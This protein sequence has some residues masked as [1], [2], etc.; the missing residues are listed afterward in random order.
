MTN[1]SAYKA[2][3]ITSLM[4][5]KSCWS[6]HFIKTDLSLSIP[7]L[8][9]SDL[10]PTDY[11]WVSIRWVYCVQETTLWGYVCKS[12]NV[13]KEMVRQIWVSLGGLG[14]IL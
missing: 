1:Y 4:K 13:N 9:E 14:M 6:Q 2:S 12:H 10:K 8:S 5:D 11:K 3:Q 7:K